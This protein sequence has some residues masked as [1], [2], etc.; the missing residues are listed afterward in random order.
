MKCECKIFFHQQNNFHTS[1]TKN[2]K[3]KYSLKQIKK[4]KKNSMWERRKEGI[5]AE[6]SRGAEEQRNRGTEER[7]LIL[8]WRS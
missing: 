1:P 8:H 5:T 3:L 7:V 2:V 4:N 6:R